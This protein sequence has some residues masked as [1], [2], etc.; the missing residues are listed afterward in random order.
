MW[1]RTTSGKASVCGHPEAGTVG[2][3]QG[4]TCAHS[5][6]LITDAPAQ[7]FSTTNFTPVTQA[8]I[9]PG[10]HRPLGK[11]G[12]GRRGD[13]RGGGGEWWMG[14]VGEEGWIK[15]KKNAE[16]QSGTQRWTSDT[17]GPEPSRDKGHF[18]PAKRRTTGVGLLR[19][20]PPL[21]R[22][23]AASWT[24]KARRTKRH[25]QDHEDPQ[26]KMRKSAAER[27]KTNYER[28]N[29]KETK[30]TRFETANE[31]PVAPSA[32]RQRAN[33]HTPTAPCRRSTRREPGPSR[34]RGREGRPCFSGQAASVDMGGA[35]VHR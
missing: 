27:N 28:N 33:H 23:G 25:A 29:E 21:P 2:P 19:K 31:R 8:E 4:R 14:R 11:G 34:G 10:K 3:G 30:Q 17:G 26:G 1:A 5:P 6:T 13:G 12:G 24:R 20:G 15:T 9:I 16:L 18:L 22:L 32:R 7:P 35:T